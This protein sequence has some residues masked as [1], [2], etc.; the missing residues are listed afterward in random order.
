MDAVISVSPRA[1]TTFWSK[2]AYQL[3]IAS[4]LAFLALTT[5]GMFIYPGG[6]NTDTTSPGYQFFTNFFSD[7]G[8]T[9]AHNGTPNPF[10]VLFTIAMTS[11]GAGLALFFV[12]FARFFTQPVLRRIFAIFGTLA[13]VMAGVCFIGVGFTP[14]NLLGRPHGTFVLYGFGAFLAAAAI[15]SVIILRD[16]AYPNRYAVPFLIFALLL[17]AYMYLITQRPRIEGVDELII[18]A[19]GQKIIVYSSLVSIVLQSVA[20]QGPI[21]I[22]RAARPRGPTTAYPN[23][24]P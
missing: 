3:V 12:S 2:T 19:T 11:S 1:S 10:S 21:N 6:T 7:L 8:R 22:G 20:A 17:A 9:V 13:G 16:P 14:S 23:I 18:Q 4:I 15:Y 24:A 5:L